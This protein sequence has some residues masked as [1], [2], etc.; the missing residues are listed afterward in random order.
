[1]EQMREVLLRYHYAGRAEQAY[2]QRI[3]HFIYFL[4]PL[5]GAPQGGAVKT[6]KRFYSA[7]MQ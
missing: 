5:S 7:I 1:M 2:C 4:N 6:R 3:M